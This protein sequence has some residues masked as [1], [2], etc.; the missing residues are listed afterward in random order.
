MGKLEQWTIG[1]TRFY[2]GVMLDD[3]KHQC[4][5]FL[6]GE[7]PRLQ[8]PYGIR[9]ILEKEMSKHKALYTD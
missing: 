4:I 6:I 8:K 1:V 5:Q 9:A 2:Q 7:H 3:F